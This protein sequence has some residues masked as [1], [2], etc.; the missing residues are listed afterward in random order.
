M[1]WQAEVMTD[2]SA[3]A[4]PVGD[5]LALSRALLVDAFGRVAE[6][7]PGLLDG[8]SGED[9]LWRADPEANSIGWLVWH[10]TRVQDDHLAGVAERE[11]VWA[12]A[13]F[14]ERFGLPYAARSIG[15]GQSSD[16]V[17]AFSVT[18]GS[19]LA[20]Y[21]AAVHAETVAIVQGLSASDFQRIVDRRWDP[22]VTAAV[23]LVSVVN[24]ITQHAGQVAYLRGLVERRRG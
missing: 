17:G 1:P 21:H 11:Q 19:L 5:D 9:L 2:T 12:S 14:A 20:A 3:A 24:D 15:Y 10:L 22:P 7:L 16:E 8:L 4:T 13:G 18:D 23:R 6:G